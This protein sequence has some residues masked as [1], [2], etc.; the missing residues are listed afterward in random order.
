MARNIRIGETEQ[1][2]AVNT[3][4]KQSAG[5]TLI[6]LMIVVMIILIL[7]GMAV[8]DYTKTIRRAQEAV[9]KYDLRILRETIDHYTEDNE[10]AAQSVE[11]LR[12]AGYLRAVPVD[13]MTCS[14]GWN[15]KYSSVFPG[16][17]RAATG[18]VDVSSMSKRTALD[19]TNYSDW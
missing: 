19:G 17:A 11:D 2:T 10:A 18:L 3:Q 14:R 1:K 12:A 8:V 4:R 16:T 15:E 7:V 5:F 6:E 13:P 9:L